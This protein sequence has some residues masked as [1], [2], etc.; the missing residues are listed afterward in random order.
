MAIESRYP[1]KVLQEVE[2][3]PPIQNTANPYLTEAAMHADQDNQL[4][5]YGYL[6]DGVGAFTYLGTVAGT[7]A[8][9]EGFGG[10]VGNETD[11]TVPQYVKDIIQT[12]LDNWN[13]KLD[14]Q[15]I[16]G[17]GVNKSDTLRIIN[18]IGGQV[19][20]HFTNQPGAIKIKFPVNTT[21]G[22]TYSLTVD[23]FG[24]Q[25]NLN[26]TDSASLRISGQ[27]NGATVNTTS[28]TTLVSGERINYPVRF[29][30]DG[31]NFCIWIGETTHVFDSMTSTI[32]NLNV[33]IAIAGSSLSDWD[34][35]FVISRVTSFDTV[36]L[37]LTDNLPL[38]KTIGASGTFTTVDSKTVTV[39]DGIITSIV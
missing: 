5:G 27:T 29:G 15:R 10:G 6:V 4:Q 2:P 1:L 20:H 25:Y 26:T 17:A 32:T 38:A 30:N 33:S 36:N 21:H 23:I 18:P 13:G 7:A 14:R 16:A 19:R 35:P 31:T 9:Y 12:D 11:P 37:L 34:A 39:T 24:R 8:D 22:A 3:F 28:V